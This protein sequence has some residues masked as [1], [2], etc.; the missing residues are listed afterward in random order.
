VNIEERVIES[1][2]L[3]KKKGNP[4]KTTDTIKKPGT[5]GLSKKRIIRFT[6]II[7]MAV[8]SS[9]CAHGIDMKLW[10]R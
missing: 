2:W 5:F 8:G 10:F 1:S 7:N 3:K 6:P 9:N 4:I